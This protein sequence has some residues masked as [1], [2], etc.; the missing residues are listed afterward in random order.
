M[1]DICI[2]PTADFERDQVA[3][4]SAYVGPIQKHDIL[5]S[6]VVWI[7]GITHLKIDDVLGPKRDDMPLLEDPPREADDELVKAMRARGFD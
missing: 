3:K 4:Y 6:A 2:R 7:Q 5:I 1:S